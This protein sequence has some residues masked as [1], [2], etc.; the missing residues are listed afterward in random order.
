MGSVRDH[1]EEDIR[2]PHGGFVA[3]DG[4][5]EKYATGC[6]LAVGRVQE[7]VEGVG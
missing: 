6:N 1:G 5:T 3:G 7:R 4:E 2:S